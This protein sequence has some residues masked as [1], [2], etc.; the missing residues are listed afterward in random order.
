MYLIFKNKLETGLGHIL[1]VSPAHNVCLT[2]SGLYYIQPPGHSCLV[3]LY[4]STVW[5]VFHAQFPNSRFG[6]RKKPLCQSSQ[7]R[8]PVYIPFLICIYPISR[9]TLAYT[10]FALGQIFGSIYWKK[11]WT[12]INWIRP[13]GEQYNRN[14][15]N[16]EYYK[17]I[18]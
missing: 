13:T 12:Q 8:A 1:C 18:L 6:P 7:L 5:Y 17:G 2:L 4:S 11:G 10:T 9:P 15:R 16:T 3:I 14:Q